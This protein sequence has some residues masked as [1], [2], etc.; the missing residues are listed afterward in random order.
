MEEVPVSYGTGSC[1][2]VIW[3][4]NIILE[5]ATCIENDSF[6]IGTQHHVGPREVAEGPKRQK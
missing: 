3:W 1:S 4:V 2:P 6:V 5:L